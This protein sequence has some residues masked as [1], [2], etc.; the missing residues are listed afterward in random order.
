MRLSTAIARAVKQACY[1]VCGGRRS[2]ELGERDWPDKPDDADGTN[3]LLWGPDND[4]FE[5]R[6]VN[7]FVGEDIDDLA[8]WVALDC[9]CYNLPLFGR[10]PDDALDTNVYVLISPAGEVMYKSNDHVGHVQEIRRILSGAGI[11]WNPRD[12]TNDE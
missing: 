1:D 4:L 5:T 11:E 8:E 10:E 7:D 9:Y 6:P 12:S 3:F 2:V